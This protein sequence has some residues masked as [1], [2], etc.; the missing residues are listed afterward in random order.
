MQTIPNNT[1]LDSIH[2]EPEFSAICSIGKAP[3]HGMIEIDY[4]P[5]K[6]LIEFESFEIWLR[7]EVAQKHLTIEDLAQL[8][9][10]KLVKALGDI[11]LRVTIH[12]RTTVH[13]PVKAT[14]SNKGYAP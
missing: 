10:D 9:F 8:T 1:D 7:T 6:V 13:A 5:G 14:I 12:A 11:P 3:F 2:Y 4:Q